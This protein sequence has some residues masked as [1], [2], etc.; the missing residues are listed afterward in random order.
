MPKE[1]FLSFDLGSVSLKTVVLDTDGSLLHEEYLR[2][3]G[4]PFQAAVTAV[5]KL[6]DLFPDT[7][8]RAAASTGSGGKRLAE[9][10]GIRFVNEIIALNHGFA[11]IAPHVRTAIEIGGQDSKLLLLKPDAVRPTLLDFSMN[12]LCAAGTGS[13]LDQQATRLGVA[14]EQEFGELAQRSTNPP[15]IAGRCSVFAKSDMIHLQQIATPV[16]DIAAGLCL[17]LARSFKS[18]VGKGKAFAAPIA[19]AG[20]VSSNAGMVAAF[21][22]ILNLQPGELLIPDHHRTVGAIGVAQILHEENVGQTPPL[23]F[24]K[25]LTDLETLLGNN[26][27]TDRK[28]HV[29]LRPYLTPLALPDNS[30][31]ALPLSDKKIDAY[32]GI[33]IGS[34]STNVVAIDSDNRLLAKEYLWTSSRPIEAVRQGLE[35]V[36]RSIGHKINVRAAA[37]TGSGRY[38]IG[39]LFGADIIRNE[40]TA[41][42]I[43]AI[44]IDPDVDTIFEI[45]GQDSKYISIQHGAV[46]DFEMN[47]A[48]AAGTGSFLAEQAERLGINLKRDF[49]P[50]ALDATN[51]ICL[52]DRCT[53]FMESDLVH[54][55]Q[56]GAETA[57]LLGGLAYSIAQNYLHRVVGDRK[58]GARIF[59]QGGTAFN[60]AVVAAFSQILGK[61]ICVPAHHE[62]TG[63]I[64]AAILAKENAKETTK[65]R[66]FDLE[67]LEFETHSFVCK[68]CDNLC[69]IRQIKRTDGPSLYYGSRCEKYEVHHQDTQSD[70]PDLFAEREKLISTTSLISPVKRPR[71]GIPVAL[72]FHDSL[73]FWRTFFE[74]LG[75]EVVLSGPTTQS[76]IRDGIESVNVD[77]CFPVKVAH[78]HILHL[79]EKLDQP[80]D[81]LFL[82]SLIDA[83]TPDFGP[84]DRTT[85]NCPLVQTLPYT[86]Q[87]SIPYHKY[88]AQVFSPALNPQRGL[89]NMATALA[90]HG[91]LLKANYK[92]ILRALKKADA[93]QGAFYHALEQR[94][95]ELL[96]TLRDT[97][98][99]GL[100]IVS[101]P[102]N[103]CD[104]GLNLDLPRKI[105][106]LGALPI[107]ME[108]LP[109][110][111]T[112]LPHRWRK[113]YWRYAQRIL[114]AAEI[115]KHNPNLFAVYI[116][117][118]SCG[119]DSFVLDCFRSEMGAKPHL[120]L[121]IDEHS[122]DAGLITRCEA[123]LDTLENIKRQEKHLP[124]HPTCHTAAL[125]QTGQRRIFIPNMTPHVYPV[126]AALRSIG[127]PAQVMASSS[128]ESLALGM[129]HTSGRECYPCQLTTG[130]IVHQTQ[131]PD[132]NPEGDAFLM[133]SADGPC[134]FGQ[135]H[136]LHRRVLDKLGLQQVPVLNLE[137]DESYG[138]MPLALTPQFERRAFL[139]IVAIDVFEKL[140]TEKRPVE[141]KPGETERWF[142]SSIDRICT[143][144]E[145]SMTTYWATLEELAREFHAIPSSP[146]NTLPRIG[147]VGEIYV[148]MNSFA[149]GDLIK[150]VES[151]G[152]QA[153]LP[154]MTEWIHYTRHNRA[155]RHLHLGAWGKA[156]AHAAGNFIAQ[157][158]EEKIYRIFGKT[159]DV[160]TKALF[161]Y[162]KPYLDPSFKGEAILTIGKAVEMIAHDGACGIINTLPF[163]CMPGT[164]CAALF[165]RV[166]ENHNGVPVLN[167]AFAGQQST[168]NHARLEAF[169]HQ[170]KA[171]KIKE[172]AGA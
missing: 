161:E 64:G 172:P 112:P 9:A 124:S 7:P 131:Q 90:K 10:L 104:L 126:A 142:W 138:E 127:I 103:G 125:P 139:G 123:F 132:F 118:F 77:I 170:A 44:A 15:R 24:S 39:E 153:L 119:P 97:N 144:L 105:R 72:S 36:R 41:Q 43:A 137:Q 79:L 67:N 133:A 82:P 65:F 121:E 84:R 146:P 3:Q 63:A 149:N 135:Y 35:A 99:T 17:A 117:N 107:P 89:K 38:L 88:P 168:D 66:G 14:I 148:R 95:L 28:N 46:C 71:V 134:R 110:N 6:V 86:S 30:L 80:E 32:I 11:R 98:Q 157:K 37:T 167:L 171:W 159:T 16:H 158:G 54:H 162:A 57:D 151:L 47:K 34:V 56:Q 106:N 78:G 48:C 166:R 12:A 87:G 113:V 73:P 49:S 150:T 91:D 69:E 115:I 5:K 4:R 111:A 145:K 163:T 61:E 58:I 128:A 25:I 92:A 94:G 108:M 75:Y 93:A 109:L 143:A 27:S 18:T 55:Q 20:G 101:R 31:P 23:T 62:V 21:E 136:Q 40:I 53:V 102:Y 74:S 129:R 50:M 165:K 33:D 29:P 22:N 83:R 155:E 1:L 154:T 8:I 45:G 26:A 140:L 51:P 81:I 70:L 141:N 85:F 68:S 96:K 13:F 164:I 100:V 59:F 160:G 116:T 2:T 76:L 156:L 122:A 147:I 152:A 19:F 120:L 130:D 114:K 42:A 52:G 60:K 169:V